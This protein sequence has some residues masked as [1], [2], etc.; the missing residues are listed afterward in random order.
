M[1]FDP[2]KRGK[3]V[4]RA[5]LVVYDKQAGDM[6][7]GVLCVRNENEGIRYFGDLINNRETLVGMHPADFELRSIG[8]LET[9]DDG[10]IVVIPWTHFT[11]P[12]MTGERMLA[13]TN[14]EAPQ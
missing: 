9:K 5:L 8:H 3:T 12:L 1:T 14:R 6:I 11:T 2:L 7:G 13:I 4:K 10:D